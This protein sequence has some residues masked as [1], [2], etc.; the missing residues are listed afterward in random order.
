MPASAV[1][2]QVTLAW[3]AS[4]DATVVG[5]N[6]Y[7]GGAS[8]QYTNIVSAGG[9][10]SAVISNLT[11]GAT[12]Y[13]AATSVDAAGLEST[14]SG[15]VMYQSLVPGCSVSLSG[16]TRVYDGSP[17]PVVATTSPPGLP[18]TLTY[19]G[20]P[21]VP[22][23]AGTYVVVA[24]VTGSGYLGGATNTL[25]IS[26]AA[27]SIQLTGLNQS[28]DGTPKNIG[29]L[30]TPPGLSVSLAYSGSCAP[31]VN[32]GA[33]PVAATII[34]PNY[35]G[36]T[37]STLVISPATAPIQFSGLNQNYDGSPKTVV[38]TTTPAGLTVSLTYNGRP[39][40]PVN[41][42][43]YEVIA[44]VSSANYLGNA[45]ATLVVSKAAASI[46]LA[47]LNPACDG[48]PKTVS[49]AT[50]PPGL[51][52]A[53]TYNGQ[54]QAPAWPGSYSV[55]A[56]IC[57]A[58]Y[59]GAT[60]NTLTIAKTKRLPIAGE[61]LAG[62]PTVSPV[63][64]QLTPI[65]GLALV[66]R[67]PVRTNPVSIFASADLATWTPVATIAGATGSWVVRSQQSSVFF[68][69]LDAGTGTTN[70]VP[71][72]IQPGINPNNVGSDSFSSPAG[73]P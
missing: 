2:E 19:N 6:I 41:A 4:P 15:E 26:A 9:A 33:Y 59:G 30:T 48:T 24:T 65:P 68:V 8:Q 51:A 16:L 40:A 14:Y 27:A 57:D 64:M 44:N 69:A 38:A 7:Y 56:V 34:D 3:D 53:L 62:S 10:T 54:R 58:N 32:A 21:N 1:A 13:F 66:L 72:A 22:V 23:N 5:Y 67:W 39:N 71:L 42:G 61:P 60:T 70:R 73:D 36:A 63:A 29:A 25:V 49:A 31:P 12:Y 52:V 55:V 45:T 37:S 47:G 35:V 11:A 46:Q 50:I 18:V 20:L 17:K 28:Y 43:R